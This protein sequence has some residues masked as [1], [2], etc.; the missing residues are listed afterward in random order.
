MQ[1]ALAESLKGVMGKKLTIGLIFVLVF[2]V[3]P[4]VMVR[5][6]TEHGLI[7][8]LVENLYYLPFS[9]F[10]EEPF[11]RKIEVGMAPLIWGRIVAGISYVAV[12][13]VIT[14]LIRRARSR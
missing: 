5:W 1:L 2:P 4:Y 13:T 6:D 14:F 9:T 11:F 10:L 12:I 3:V 7:W 8:I